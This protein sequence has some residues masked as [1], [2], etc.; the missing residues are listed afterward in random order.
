VEVYKKRGR[1]NAGMKEDNGTKMKKG[2]KKN[3]Q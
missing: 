3:K 1:K 2:S